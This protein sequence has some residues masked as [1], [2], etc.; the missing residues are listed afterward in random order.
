MVWLFAELRSD[1]ILRLRVG[2]R[3][4][5]QF[6]PVPTYRVLGTTSKVMPPMIPTS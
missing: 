1:E 2:L 6:I 3:S 4:R 5:Q